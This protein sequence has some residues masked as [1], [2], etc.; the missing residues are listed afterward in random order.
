MHDFAICTAVYR[1]GL[2][3]FDD[4]CRGLAAA[5]RRMGEVQKLVLVTDGLDPVDLEPWVAKFDALADVTVA[6]GSGGPAA[7]RRQM[8]TVAAALG[9]TAIACYDMDDVPL[10]YGLQRH[11]QTLK[12]GDIAFGDMELIDEDG[13]SLNRNFFAGADVPDR[14]ENPTGLLRR[15]FLGF[16]N[17]AFRTDLVHRAAPHIPDDIV[18]ADWWFFTVLAGQGYRAVKTA[19]PVVAYRSH[20]DSMLGG[21]PST[22]G[23]DI[24]RRC[25]VIRNHYA[26]L[27]DLPGV[28]QEDQRVSVL[29]DVLQNQPL[30]AN[31][32]I[33]T[34]RRTGVWYEDVFSLLDAMES[35]S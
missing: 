19:G 11:R 15:N 23:A 9:T 18:A 14:L 20:R 22:D 25:A 4:Y 24:L 33:E 13:N 29:Q 17:T 30:P 6:K 2:R 3:F 28:Q 16:T 34:P 31:L 26:H 32:E 27:S 7:V 21:L 10:E 12:K 35:A 1:S 8:L 5:L